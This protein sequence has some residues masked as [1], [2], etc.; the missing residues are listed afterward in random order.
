MKAV[1]VIFFTPVFLFLNTNKTKPKA[2]NTVGL[3]GT[4][5]LFYLLIFFVSFSSLNG[6]NA[7]DR[8]GILYWRNEH[9]TTTAATTTTTAN[10]KGQWIG[11]IAKRERFS[12]LLIGGAFGGSSTLNVDITV[13]LGLD[14]SRNE[15]WGSVGISSCNSNN[16]RN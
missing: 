8:C 5:L 16:N 1:M 14:W 15:L 13:S 9:K 3:G 7:K 10:W 2:W 6:T 4:L 12:R 11:K